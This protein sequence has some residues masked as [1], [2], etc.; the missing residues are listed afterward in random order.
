M[1]TATV[2]GLLGSDES[3]NE[4]EIQTGLRGLDEGVNTLR[5]ADYPEEATGA[6]EHVSTVIRDVMECDGLVILDGYP[7]GQAAGI[8]T[9]ISSIPAEKPITMYLPTEMQIEGVSP[10]VRRGVHGYTRNL[11]DALEFLIEDLL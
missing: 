6:D 4:F 3:V 1:S 5:M 9:F 10:W 11:A 7:E 8:I 2:I